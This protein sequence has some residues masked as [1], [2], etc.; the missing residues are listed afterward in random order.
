VN[1]SPLKKCMDKGNEE[2]EKGIK[3]RKK[4]REK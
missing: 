4:I 2:M 1:V 3:R